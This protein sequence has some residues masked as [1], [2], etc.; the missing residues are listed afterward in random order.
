MRWTFFILFAAIMQVSASAVAQKIS[1]S[2]SNADMQTLFKAIRQQSGYNFLYTDEQLKSA[3]PVTIKVRSMELKEVLE[4]L[5]KDQPLTYTIDERTV[6]VKDAEKP[7]PVWLPEY[8]ATIDVTGQV[9]NEMGRPMQHASVRLL[10]ARQQAMTDVDGKFSFTKVPENGMLIVSYIG[11]KTDTIAIGGRTSILIRM[12]PQANI[13]GEISVVS[14]G[15]QDLPKE[16]ATG[17][18]EVVTAK[19]LQH[20]VDPNLLRRLEG[21]ATG[22]DFRNDLRPMNSSNP[23]AS[24]SPL[25]NLTIRGK[26]TL[27]DAVSADLN[28]NY[29]GQVLVVIDGIASPYPIDRI[30]PNDV[31]SITFLKDAAA[32]SIWGSRAANG[33]I[34]VKTK[35]GAYSRK[36]VVTF[37]SSVNVAEK[38][39]LL[40]NKTMG[41]SDFVDA[42]ILRFTTDNRPLSDISITTLYG[43]EPVSPVAEIMNA[44]KFKHTLTDAEATAQLNAL[45]GNDIR[46]DYTKHF[47]RNAVTQSYSLGVDG[48]SQ[49]VNYRLS[50]G[51][52]K[53]LNNTQNSSYD[54]MVLTYNTSARP[55]KNLELQGGIT[56]S[57]QN[58]REQ[59]PENRITGV[60][61]G[62]FYPYNRLTDELGNPAQITKTY[63]PGFVELFEQTYGNKYLSMRY[64][65][66]E[67]INEGYNRVRS[68][69]LNINI[70]ANYKVTKWLSAQL[71]YNYN[72]GRNE[73]NV[74]YRQNSFFMRNLINYFTTS[75]ASVDPMTYDPV[76]PYV[77]Q[78]PAGGRYTTQLTTSGNRT[79]RGQLNIDKSWKEKHQV[80]AI[81]GVDI[82][83]NTS[84]VKTDGY[85]GYDESTRRSDNKLDYKTMIPILFAEDFNGYNGEY[86][87][88]LSTGF[89]DLKIRTWSW[90]SNAAY[91]YDGRY[92]LSASVRKDLSSEFGMGTNQH[93]TPYFSVGGSWNINRESFYH[94]ELFPMLRL[95]TTFGYNGNVNPSVLARPLITYSFFNGVN[96]LPY[97]FTSFGSGVTNT[98]LRPEK[99]GILNIGLDFETK[100]RRLSGSLEYYLKHTTDLI[101]IGALDP[102]TGYT[103][104]NFNT[105]N[106]KGYGIDLTLNSLNVQANKF[107]W[108]STLLFSYNRVKVTR[109]YA[110]AASMAGSVVNNGSGSY[111]EGFDL[112]R[113][114]GY[115]WAGLD[116]QTGDPR[117]YLKGQPVSISSNAAGL[118]N[119]NQIQ[120]EPISSLTY[121]GSAVP[122]YYGAF[123]NT[124][125]YASI[126]LS[127]NLMYKLGY[128]V[129]RPVAQVVDYS[130]LYGRSPILQ[131]VEYN[132]RW[133]QPGDELRTDVPSAVYAA[134][135]QYRDQFYY[136]SD[137]N[138]I[139]GD[140]VRL[141][142]VNLSYSFPGKQG[143]FIKNPRVYGNV[144]NIGIIWK[145]NKAGVDPEVFDYPNPRS[146]NIGFSANF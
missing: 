96:D 82:T 122:V 136:Y 11:Y 1:L 91:T 108:N 117:G 88:N 90:Y 8:L 78:L 20:S 55:V 17:S 26:N 100:G 139:K 105:G 84:L 70:G 22:L 128:F 68:Q 72:T 6:V 61:N 86:I 14:S 27:N 12:S 38:I 129:R 48:G 101:S 62:V 103:N 98:K 131:G 114:F 106:L 4:L 93:A 54:R 109:L 126:S 143:S 50:V 75:P 76:P 111:N 121:F 10:G 53:T 123:R 64:R 18:F 9:F 43:Q 144:S 56:Y 31:E 133:K 110:A 60:T 2:A 92:T 79:V 142:E 127:A 67:D 39:D 77:Q 69:N 52:D 134:N 65:P 71:T 113:L 83:Q 130:R 33:V 5:F 95:R 63:R 24:R 25:G 140:H 32:A 49:N 23:N 137:I 41:I 80:S 28:G 3:K 58:N 66:L 94:F 40:Y 99:T 34:V 57:N 89:T 19:Q 51:Y 125:T 37:N 81:A 116:P 15:Y 47:L 21:I 107:R 97:V 46:K 16:R 120:R 146:Y 138:V 73:D 29:S 13:I 87:P 102:S 118:N 36:M 112:S 42:E 104:I 35:K 74:L 132:T 141:Q 145:A 124:F 30:N 115:K 44:W 85:Y 45:R 119:Y 7:L 59:A 135:N